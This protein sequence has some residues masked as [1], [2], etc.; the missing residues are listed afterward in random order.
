[1]ETVNSMSA[2]ASRIIKLP[3][4]GT[5][6]V[7]ETVSR[8]GLHFSISLF[9]LFG[10]DSFGVALFEQYCVIFTCIASGDLCNWW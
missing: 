5:N 8:P 10:L 4:S 2:V 9:A 3:T 6:H 1:M 7:Q